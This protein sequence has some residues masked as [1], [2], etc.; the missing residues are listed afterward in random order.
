MKINKKKA[1]ALTAEKLKE[2]L[3]YDKNTGVF[4]WRVAVS[5][6]IKVGQI[7]GSVQKVHK[8][9]MVGIGGYYYYAHRLAWLY[10]YGC[11]PDG[12]RWQIDHIDGDRSNNRIENLK[13]VPPSENGKNQKMKSNNTSGVTGVQRTRDINGTKTGFNY[14]WTAVWSNKEGKQKKKRFSI[15]KLG[16]VVAEQLAINY[17]A[18]Q[19]YLLESEHNITYS[20]RHG[21]V[22]D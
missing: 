11:F 17:R 14:Y 2:L 7:A 1:N 10:T 16:E 8:Y 12:D 22:D 15:L 20:D 4:T 18:E 13:T 5:N 21:S 9:I 19:L 6:K 3:N